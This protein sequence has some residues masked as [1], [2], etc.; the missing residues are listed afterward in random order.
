MVAKRICNSCFKGIEEMKKLIVSVAFA[1]GLSGCASLDEIKF[2]RAVA[3]KVTSEQG[4]ADL[5]KKYDLPTDICGDL[6]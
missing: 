3:C 1:M 5:R 2:S 6:N 4:R